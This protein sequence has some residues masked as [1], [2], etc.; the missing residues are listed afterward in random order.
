VRARLALALG[1]LAAA[2]CTKQRPKERPPLADPIASYDGDP[3]QAMK[4]ELADQILAAYQRDEPPEVD[5]ATISPEIGPARIGVGPGDVL[6]TA[7]DFARAPSR[8]PLFLAA[9]AEV[10]SRRLDVQLARDRSAAYVSD[11]LAWRIPACGR[12]ATVPMRLTALYAHDG[13][14]WVQVFEHLSFARQPTIDK[15]GLV[16]RPFDSALQSRDLADELSRGVARASGFVADDATLLGPAVTD[17]WTGPIAVAAIPALA[18]EDRRVGL[19]GRNPQTSTIAYWVGNFTMGGTGK[20]RVRGTFVF[21]LRA[22]EQAP[23]DPPPAAPPKKKFGLPRTSEARE[24]QNPCTREGQACR[25]VLVQA[26]VS[27]PIRD[28]DL[29][30]TVFGVSLAQPYVPEQPLGVACD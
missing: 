27:Q 5:T 21:E 2:A 3:V 25:W 1:A 11:E 6:I 10:R 18:S 12:I 20:I 28:K 8:W 30:T 7:D 4:A 14:R 9:R 23:S 26:H 19:V 15:T 17:L 13:D 29:A 24:L 16:G 22:H